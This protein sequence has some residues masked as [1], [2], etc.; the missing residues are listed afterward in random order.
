MSLVY[1]PTLA[2]CDMQVP[3]QI[4][5]CA[6]YRLVWLCPSV[7]QAIGLE[8]FTYMLHCLKKSD[9]AKEPE[10]HNIGL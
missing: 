9:I 6:I 1:A 2:N 8:A 7:Q 4:S 10:V 3:G 5:V